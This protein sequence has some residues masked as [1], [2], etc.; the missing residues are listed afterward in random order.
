M[1][2]DTRNGSDPG[3]A[4]WAPDAAAPFLPGRTKTSTCAEKLALLDLP[5][6]KRTQVRD[7]NEVNLKGMNAEYIS[8]LPVARRR[9][10][11]PSKP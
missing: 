1:I 7:F 5:R 2:Y 10:T 11:I 4:E 9:W 3:G 6:E 8:R